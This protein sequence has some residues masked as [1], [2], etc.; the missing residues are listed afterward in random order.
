MCLPLFALP[1]SFSVPLVQQEY[2]VSSGKIP[3]N[4]LV[5]AHGKPVCTSRGRT[6]DSDHPQDRCQSFPLA[7]SCSGRGES[8]KYIST[9]IVAG[10]EEEKIGNCALAPVRT[11]HFHPRNLSPSVPYLFGL[12]GL[13]KFYQSIYSYLTHAHLIYNLSLLAELGAKILLFIKHQAVVVVCA[14]R[15]RALAGSLPLYENFTLQEGLQEDRGR[16]EVRRDIPSAF[17]ARM[18]TM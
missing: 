5:Q 6:E 18:G 14:L 11:L 16:Y 10:A 9:F 12:H 7:S 3:S 1:C 13:R 17:R 4:W 15:H 2:K 8:S